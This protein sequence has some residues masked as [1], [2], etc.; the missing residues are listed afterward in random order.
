MVRKSILVKDLV[1]MRFVSVKNFLII[2][3]FEKKVI[4]LNPISQNNV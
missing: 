4:Y 3:T 1:S 2:M